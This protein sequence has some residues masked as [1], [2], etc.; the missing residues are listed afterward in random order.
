M[1]IQEVEKRTNLTRAN[2]R[3]YEK[4]GLLKPLRKANGYR[5]YSSDDVEVLLKIK[6]MRE[7]DVSIEEI[8]RLQREEK[9]LSSVLEERVENIDEE[10]ENLSDAKIVCQS[11]E[12]D[13][14]TFPALEAGKYLEELEQL[15][16]ERG[17]E[18]AGQLRRKQDILRETLHPW[19]RYFARMID[20][21]IYGTAF[22]LLFYLMFHIE[23]SIVSKVCLTV[24]G[25]MV[26]ILAESVLL[27]CF[28]TTIGKWLFGIRVLSKDG[29]KLTW[30]EAAERTG[31][32]LWRGVAFE[33]PLWNIY[34]LYKSYDAY[35]DGET[36]V[37]DENCLYLIDEKKGLRYG[38]AVA[39]VVLMF[40]ADCIFDFPS[41]QIYKLPV[42]YDGLT[43]EEF[44]ENYNKYLEIY[45]LADEE[46]LNRNGEWEN[47]H[48]LRPQFQYEL[49]GDVIKGIS[50][51]IDY[52]GKEENPHY[53]DEVTCAALAW[54]GGKWK[55]K[56]QIMAWGQITELEDE[57]QKLG[58]AGF[59][60][61]DI[62]QDIIEIYGYEEKNGGF[63]PQISDDDGRLHIVFEMGENPRVSANI[64]R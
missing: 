59:E 3:F 43:V 49:E 45:G 46:R 7:L 5:D 35:T 39:V 13:G 11:I 53:R 41:E 1:N 57:M 16:K 18:N 50:F 64:S 27:S 28:G 19:R 33:I 8:D 4:Q 42:H 48:A 25:M 23:D 21:G 15:A 12:E 60:A 14:A 30:R 26:F 36:L 63:Y 37:W 17:A 44:A 31:M 2:I 58:C 32:V 6:L 62:R 54:E 61:D 24:L 52:T 29:K 34:R 22:M 38:A 40:I 47:V 51:E 20:G 56:W 9:S 55:N 10:R